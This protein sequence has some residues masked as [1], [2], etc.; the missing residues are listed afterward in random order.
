[1]S[2]QK[3]PICSITFEHLLI[4]L[5]IRVASIVN[6]ASQLQDEKGP[7]S[8]APFSIYWLV[9][10]QSYIVEVQVGG[11]TVYSEAVPAAGLPAATVYSLNSGNPI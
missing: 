1:M 4:G 5:S 11:G 9:P 8:P 6:I 2:R 3:T 7:S 10:D